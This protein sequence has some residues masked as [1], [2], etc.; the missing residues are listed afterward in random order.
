M[1]VSKWPD[2]DLAQARR[3][4]AQTQASRTALRTAA[5]AAEALGSGGEAQQIQVW[6]RQPFHTLSSPWR[7]A[8]NAWSKRTMPA[9]N[10]LADG[11]FGVG[12][13]A[14]LVLA[15]SR[16]EQGVEMAAQHTTGWRTN[17]WHGHEFILR[18][19]GV[20]LGERRR[21]RH[22]QIDDAEPLDLQ[23]LDVLEVGHH[24]STV[25]LATLQRHQRLRREALVQLQRHVRMA[26]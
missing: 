13:R 2:D 22:H 23:P 3:L 4:S 18:R 1:S 7:S 14:F 26:F 19:I 16:G 12:K 6:P 8:C 20:R 11:A 24:I 15:A 9:P 5:T 21:Q 10:P 17:P 25:Q